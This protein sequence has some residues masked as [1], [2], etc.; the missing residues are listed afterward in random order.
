MYKDRM[1]F[2]S[3]VIITPCAPNYFSL[4]IFYRNIW[5]F[6]LFK[7]LVQTSHKQNKWCIHNFLNKTNGKMLWLKVIVTSTEG[8]Y[9]GM[10]FLLCSVVFRPFSVW[11][12]IPTYFGSLYFDSQGKDKTPEERRIAIC[13]FDDVAEQCRDSALR[14]YDTYLPF[15]LEAANDENSDV[16]QVCFFFYR[17]RLTHLF[18]LSHWTLI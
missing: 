11:G 17:V 5:S 13:I 3:L 15:L 2:F 7:K 8:E 14:Y 4:L 1:G 16:R 6:V 10:L 9:I 18:L 12:F